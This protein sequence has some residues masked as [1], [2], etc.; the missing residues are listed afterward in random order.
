MA[1][2][3]VTAAYAYYTGTTDLETIEAMICIAIGQIFIGLDIAV[4]QIKK[5]IKKGRNI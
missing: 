2:W 3:T 4:V 5:Q 1:V